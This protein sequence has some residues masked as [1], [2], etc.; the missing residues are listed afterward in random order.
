MKQSYYMALLLSLLG[1]LLPR[2]AIRD[3]HEQCHQPRDAC[4]GS[5]GLLA[6]GPCTLLVGDTRS[7]AM[8]NRLDICIYP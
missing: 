6:S 2:S 3:Y 8:G 7:D 4:S 1:P 5:F